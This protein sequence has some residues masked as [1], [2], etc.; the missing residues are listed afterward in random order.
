MNKREKAD[1]QATIA[2]IAVGGGLL[3][4]GAGAYFLLTG[5]GNSTSSAKRITTP[6]VTADGA[7]FLMQESFL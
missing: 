2:N 6:W 1:T 7:G 4:L 5:G 3:L